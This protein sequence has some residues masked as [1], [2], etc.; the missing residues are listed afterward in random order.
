MR[1]ALSEWID[2]KKG[3]SSLGFTK[4]V[5]YLAYFY[6][7]LTNDP[8]FTASNIKGYFDLADVTP[9]S[10]VNQLCNNLVRKKVFVPAI[11]GYK[12]HRETY[13]E[14]EHEFA[15]D[16]PKRTVSKKLRDLLRKVE[17]SQNRTFLSEA[18]SCYEIGA[19]RAAIVMTWLLVVDNLHEY[20]LA[21][22]LIE[23]NTALTLQNLKLKKIMAKEDF[24]ELKEVK[25]IEIARSANIISNDVRKILDEKLGTRNTCAHP[26][27]IIVKE[28][29][30]TSFIE[31]LVD[32]VLLKYTK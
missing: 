15:G 8:I 14:L 9:P 16:K 32:N 5:K 31:D 28:S 26:N 20:I 7:K 4:Q 2:R 18:I 24:N 22:K 10:N 29:K 25:F 6:I 23:F 27:N 3:F 30:A 13:Q 19:Y 21:H 17:L 12:L 11:K 1:V